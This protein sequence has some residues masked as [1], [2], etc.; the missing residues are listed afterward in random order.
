MEQKRQEEDLA[1][2]GVNAIVNSL[3]TGEELAGDG[4]AL[5]EPGRVGTGVGQRYIQWCPACKDCVGLL[6]PTPQL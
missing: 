6:P 1:T 2:M 3:D 5:K 4:S